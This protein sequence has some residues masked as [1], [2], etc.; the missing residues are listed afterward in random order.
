MYLQNPDFP[1][2]IAGSVKWVFLAVFALLSLCEWWAPKRP[3]KL[4]KPRRWT[5]HMALFVG[6]TLLFRWI[7]S[8]GSVATAAALAAAA[9]RSP[10]SLL[11]RIPMSFGWRV[12]C[13]FIALDLVHYCFHRANHS[14]YWMWR[15][16]LLHH[17]DRDFDITNNL[18]IHPA[19]IALNRLVILAAIVILAPPALA[20]ALYALADSVLGLF[21]HANVRIPPV[22][23]R[24]MRLLIVTPQLHQIHH[25]L[26]QNEQQ[27][28]I[29]VVLSWWDRVFG[30]YQG[31]LAGKGDL[32]FGV[33]EVS[34]EEC[35]RPL[36]LATGM[37]ASPATRSEAD[38][39]FHPTNRPDKQS[40]GTVVHAGRRV[41]V[42]AARPPRG[43][44]DVGVGV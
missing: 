20:V 43:S 22:L 2:L 3:M 33:A 29:G 6:S 15:L 26:D 21:V 40:R 31:E 7:Y 42:G 36:H 14:V 16:H 18:R 19:E 27:R 30:T 34:A 9:Q 12:V 35:L 4:S 13:G 1:R 25:S 28:N 37:Y 23:E 24:P 39:E 41:A 38:G 10:Y 44:R 32:Y 11:N 17:S 5:G 8:M